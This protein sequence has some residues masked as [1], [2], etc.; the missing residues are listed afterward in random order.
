[1]LTIRPHQIKSFLVNTLIPPICPLCNRSLA[2]PGICSTCFADLHLITPPCCPQC[3]LPFAH[4]QGS[5]LC[6]ACIARKPAYDRVIAALRYDDAARQLILALKH[7]D[8]LDIAPLLAQIMLA[9]SETLLSE[10][11]MIIPAP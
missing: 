4:D 6:A 1:M 11:D 3:A 8:R 2:V 7:G 5:T 10:A 9:Q